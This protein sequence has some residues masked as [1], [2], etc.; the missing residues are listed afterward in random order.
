MAQAEKV[1]ATVSRPR[2]L[3][4]SLGDKMP[5]RVHPGEGFVWLRGLRD[6]GLYF[7]RGRGFRPARLGGC[8]VLIPT[9]GVTVVKY[10]KAPKN[11]ASL[12]PAGTSPPKLE[13][14]PPRSPTTSSPLW[15]P[16][17]SLCSL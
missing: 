5:T 6:Q 17:A 3:S 7:P 12:T 8:R 10:T 1:N 2:V 15:K 16:L 13:E 4:W 11:P 14:A 9:S